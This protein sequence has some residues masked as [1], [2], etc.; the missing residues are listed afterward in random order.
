MV[1]LA[2]N[3]A[4]RKFNK[5]SIRF[6]QGESDFYKADNLMSYFFFDPPVLEAYLK[7]LT[8]SVCSLFEHHPH[9]WRCVQAVAAKLLERRQLSGVQLKEVIEATLG[10]GPVLS[11]VT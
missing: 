6:H 1:L 3:E 11:V 9:A 8:A 2:G 7:F 10:E 5:R 4:Q